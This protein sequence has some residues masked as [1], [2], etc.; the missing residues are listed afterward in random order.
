MVLLLLAARASLTLSFDSE[1]DDKLCC[2]V[3][4][5]CNNVRDNQ[6]SAKSHINN[7][8]LALTAST[9]KFTKYIALIFCT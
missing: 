7:M 5:Y 6:I 2:I 8:N 1:M 9:Q 3:L 4:L